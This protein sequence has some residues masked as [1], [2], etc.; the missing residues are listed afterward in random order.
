MDLRLAFNKKNIKGKITLPSSKS[1]SNRLLIMNALSEHHTHLSNLSKAR[2]TIIL[3]NILKSD[4]HKVDAQDAGTAYR[5]LTA[6]YAL[7]QNK[8]VYLYG[9][10]RMH[11]RPIGP[12]VDALISLGAQINY[13]GREGYPPLK[14]TG[15]TLIQTKPIFIDRSK[16]SQFVSA[17]LLIAPYIKNGLSLHMTGVRSSASYIQ[18]TLNLMQEQ[19]ISLHYKNDII[20]IKPGTY[21]HLNYHIETDWSSAVF[22]YALAMTTPSDI[23]FPG[24]RHDLLQGDQQ[25]ATICKPLGVESHRADAYIRIKSVPVIPKDNLVIHAASCPDLVPALVVGLAINGIKARI[26]NIDHLRYKESD[27]LLALKTALAGVDVNI[28]FRK[29]TMIIHGKAHVKANTS[30]ESYNDHRIAMSLALMAVKNPIII[31][32]AHCVQKSFP[33]YWTS[34]KKLGFDIDEITTPPQIISSR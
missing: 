18:M 9:Q 27:R 25:I 3:Q 6:Y 2:D 13:L 28:S 7:Q 10:E 20:Q 1:I 24:L 22:F 14:I 17:L 11:L 4:H 29:D 21:N 33:Q 19:G 31:R 8:T 23:L 30:F 12:L 15:S 34:L 5:F 16:S 26:K 32:N